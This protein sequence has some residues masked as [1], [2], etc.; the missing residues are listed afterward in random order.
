[1]KKTYLNKK[2]QKYY[3]YVVL[4]KVSR[5]RNKIVELKLLPKKRTNEFVFSILKARKY[6][7]LEIEIQVFPD[8]QNSKTN[9]SVCFLGEVLF[10]DLL[11]F[12]KASVQWNGLYRVQN[13]NLL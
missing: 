3:Q 13:L 6:L 12:S 8:C 11:T 4:L 2:V 9:L 1:M 5:S 7:K 10:R